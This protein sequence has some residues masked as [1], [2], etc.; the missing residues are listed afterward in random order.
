MKSLGE[1]TK[2][3]TPPAREAER[4]ERIEEL[5]TR[6]FQRLQAAQDKFSIGHFPNTPAAPIRILN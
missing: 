1:W 3:A 4:D 2:N 6:L 5:S